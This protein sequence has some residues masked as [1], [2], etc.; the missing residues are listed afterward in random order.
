M[1]EDSLKVN[2]NDD[3]GEITLEWDPEDPRW[4]F[5]SGLTEEELSSMITGAIQQ[6]INE[7]SEDDQE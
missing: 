3:T 2:V 6:R 7:L 5:L 1:M 4:G